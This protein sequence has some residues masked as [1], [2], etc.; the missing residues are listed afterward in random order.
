[1]VSSLLFY[2]YNEERDEVDE[3]YRVRYASGVI[4]AFQDLEGR[5]C[6]IMG[7]YVSLCVT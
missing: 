2:E 3:E 4:P 5:V 7:P 6:F 1:M